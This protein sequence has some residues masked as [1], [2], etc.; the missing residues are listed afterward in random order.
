MEANDENNN[1]AETLLEGV[2][3]RK[4]IDDVLSVILLSEKRIEKMFVIGGV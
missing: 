1:G 2:L 4:F 3:V